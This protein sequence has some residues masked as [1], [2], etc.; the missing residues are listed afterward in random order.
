MVIVL[1]LARD[2]VRYV[3]IL[4]F[5]AASISIFVVL[6]FDLRV[7]RWTLAEAEVGNNLLSKFDQSSQF[8]I[9]LKRVN[10]TKQIP[11]SEIFYCNENIKNS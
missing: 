7:N 8:A 11:A 10:K 5:I 4:L 2:R 3:A 1:Y 9:Y 6:N